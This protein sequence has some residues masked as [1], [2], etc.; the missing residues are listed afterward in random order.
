MY[1]WISKVEILNDKH[2]KLF[3][4]I[5]LWFVY[6]ASGVRD[7]YGAQCLCV[8]FNPKTTS[9]NISVLNCT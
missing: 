2:V 8:L 9:Y 7:G 4:I 3:E 1:D 5:K 6:V